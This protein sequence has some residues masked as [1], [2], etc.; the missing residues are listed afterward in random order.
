MQAAQ[1]PSEE[2]ISNYWNKTSEENL[3]LPLDK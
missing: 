3:Q 2:L 1:I